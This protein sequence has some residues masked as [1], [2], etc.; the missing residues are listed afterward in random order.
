MPGTQARSWFFAEDGKLGD[1]RPHGGS[2]KSFKA[3]PR[4]TDPT[5]FT[6][7][8]GSG[9]L[10]TALPDYHWEEH[11]AGT[12]ASFITDPLD[13]GHR[14]RRRRQGRDHGPLG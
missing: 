3:D 4:S 8:T 9:G 14:R 7:D 13:P 6:G 2:R 5:N 11:P 10:W 12:A 1:G